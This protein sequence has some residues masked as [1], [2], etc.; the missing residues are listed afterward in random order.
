MN[1]VWQELHTN[2]QQQEWVAKPSLFAETVAFYLPQCGKIVELGAGHGQDSAFFAKRGLEVVSTDIET[3]AL[4]ANLPGIKV[5][6]LDLS[7]KMPFADSSFDGVYAHLSLH[8]FTA[9]KTSAIV[10]EIERILKPGGLFAFLANSTDDPEY[11]TG[12]KIESDFFL[13][14]KVTKRYF[15]EEFTRRLTQ[16]F[17]TV[18]LDNQGETYKDRAKG[19]HNLIRYIGYK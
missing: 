11:N 18:L 19:I 16:N 5:Q 10:S 14:G 8:Y 13:I 2:Y 15:S 7:E 9:E 6:K 4:E 17:Q 1:S 12:E 3:A